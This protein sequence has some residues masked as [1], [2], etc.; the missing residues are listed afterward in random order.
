MV[1]ATAAAK[2]ET[3]PKA[4]VNRK[5]ISL[6][7]KVQAFRKERQNE[8]TQQRLAKTAGNKSEEGQPHPCWD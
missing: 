3:K 8:I 5:K 6:E 1:K 4:N 7:G 2:V